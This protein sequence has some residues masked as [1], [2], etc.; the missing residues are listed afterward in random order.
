MVS[1]RTNRT[2]RLFLCSHSH[3]TKTSHLIIKRA[4]RASFIFSQGPT[5]F[6]LTF[7]SLSFD[8]AS[9][10]TIFSSS[11][12]LWTGPI[13]P[14][15]HPPLAPPLPPQRARGPFLHL[16][17]RAPAFTLLFYSQ[18]PS[19]RQEV[20]P[21]EGRDLCPL[22]SSLPVPPQE[23]QVLHQRPAHGRQEALPPGAS[24]RQPTHSTLAGVRKP[25][26]R[27]EA[28]GSALERTSL[29]PNS[30]TVMPLRTW[31]TVN[32]REVTVLLEPHIY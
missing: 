21:P 11:S 27:S 7:K 31:V 10:V 32:R 3:K 15:P 23:C 17:N 13:R 18:P 2:P 16:S 24:F 6:F 8:L 4:F 25:C 12:P 20:R 14:E 26:S 5:E 9:W 30:P 1:P 22:C 28:S 29:W 19:L